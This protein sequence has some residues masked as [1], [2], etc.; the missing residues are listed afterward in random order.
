MILKVCLYLFC[1]YRLCQV[2]I[3]AGFKALFSEALISVCSQSD[4]FGLDFLPGCCPQ[5]LLVFSNLASRLEPIHDGHVAVH[6]NDSIVGVS[7]WIPAFA[8]ILRNR[9]VSFLNSG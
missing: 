7:V 8:L 2:P 6:E 4:D 5:T 9:G 1:R 3:H